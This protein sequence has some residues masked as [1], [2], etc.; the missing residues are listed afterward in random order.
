MIP[1]KGPIQDFYNLLTALP[2]IFNLHAQEDG[3]QS[4]ANHVQHFECLSLARCCV[5][6]GT[7]A[8][9]SY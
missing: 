2:T 5:P 9:L 6:R 1:L 4:C 7:K 8:Q 3:A